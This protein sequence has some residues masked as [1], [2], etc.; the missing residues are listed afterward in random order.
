MSSPGR[1]PAPHPTAERPIAV[2][3]ATGEQ[4]GAVARD[5]LARRVPVRALVRN[6]DTERALAL[7]AAGAELRTADF[8]DEE[9][10]RD[11]FA[12]TSAVFAMAS[13]TPEGGVAAEA[14]HGL[15]MARAAADV[16]VPHVVYSSVGGVDRDTGIPHFESKREIERELLELG[17]PTT[18]IRPTFFMDNF[19]RFMA[20]TRDNGTLVLGL[21]MPGDVPL[22]MIAVTDVAAGSVAALLDPSRVPSGAIE[23]AGDELTGHQA[24]AAF[25]RRR[26]LSARYE[27]LP[28]DTLDDDNRAMFKWFATLPAYEADLAASRQLVPDAMTFAGW[29]GTLDQSKPVR[30]EG[31]R[32]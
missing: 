2:A 4:G 30:Q 14:E 13:P 3:G 27:E 26:A 24:A 6:P 1:P 19:I 17:V 23:L 16:D 22:Q 31:Q 29:L 9:S 12:G 7:A 28:S 15:A 32:P 8:E 18:F 21:P 11:A 25:G 5:L 20:P 10:L